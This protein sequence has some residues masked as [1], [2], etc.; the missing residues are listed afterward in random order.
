MGF[1]S[2]TEYV[3]KLITAGTTVIKA[4]QGIMGGFF[5][6][7]T[8]SGTI[9]IYDGLTTAGT[10]IMETITPTVLGYYIFPVGFS[11]G[12]TVVV[13]GTASVTVLYV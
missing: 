9:T 2:N 7:S 12:L 10:K 4:T 11:V 8:S 6:S 3:P 13:G 1:N 5:L